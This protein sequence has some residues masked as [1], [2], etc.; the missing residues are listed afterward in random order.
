LPRQ[1]WIAKVTSEN[2]VMTALSSSIPRL[3]H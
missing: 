2:P 3:N 1:R